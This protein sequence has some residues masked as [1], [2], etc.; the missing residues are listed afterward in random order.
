MYGSTAT[1]PSVELP[2]DWSVDWSA[3]SVAE[4]ATDLWD[5]ITR[6]AD[7]R[8]LDEIDRVILE[9]SKQALQD[10]ADIVNFINSDAAKPISAVENGS[11]FVDLVWEAFVS[12]H[13]D[14]DSLFGV[15]GLIEDLE[16]VAGGNVGVAE[17]LDPLFKRVSTLAEQRS[18]SIV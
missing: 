5:T 13:R 11:R 17:R 4:L 14:G 1:S 6:V 8:V 12:L 18:Y 16:A 9:R 2:L 10:R 15:D 7:G 3:L